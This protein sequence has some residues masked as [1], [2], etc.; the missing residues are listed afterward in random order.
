MRAFI[1]AVAAVA[2]TG[3]AAHYALSS[4]GWSSAAIHSNQATVRL[5]GPV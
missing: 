2:I 1:L 5:D 4:L 3:V